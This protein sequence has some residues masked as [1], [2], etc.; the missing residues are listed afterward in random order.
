MQRLQLIV[1]CVM[2]PGHNQREPVVLIWLLP[3]S[4]ALLH[5]P[6]GAHTAYPSRRS[7]PLLWRVLHQL[8]QYRQATLVHQ[9]LQSWPAGAGKHLCKA[10]VSVQRA[11]QA[12]QGLIA[13]V[14][15]LVGGMVLTRDGCVGLSVNVGR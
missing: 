14:D 11:D 5:K 10:A 7:S 12:V 2:Q 8:Q 4:S 6:P 13:D 3:C 9:R 1:S 15:G